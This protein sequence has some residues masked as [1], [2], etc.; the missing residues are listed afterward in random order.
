MQVELADFVRL[1]R[2]TSIKFVADHFRDYDSN[3]DK[4]VARSCNK[5]FKYFVLFNR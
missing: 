1:V 4:L 3:R 2:L 5:T